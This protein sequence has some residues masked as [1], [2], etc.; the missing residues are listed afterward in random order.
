PGRVPEDRHG[1]GLRGQMDSTARS[2][3]RLRGWRWNP[4]GR[5][6]VEGAPEQGDWRGAWQR[7]L[8]HHCEEVLQLQHLRQLERFP[9]KAKGPPLRL[10]LFFYVAMPAIN[11]DRWR[12][13][14][15]RDAR[16]CWRAP[17]A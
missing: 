17:R 1:Q 12:L 6:G 9:R 11:R 15:S 7:H 4:Q 14:P 8:R 3:L 10:A 5:H 2:D 13:P 16:P